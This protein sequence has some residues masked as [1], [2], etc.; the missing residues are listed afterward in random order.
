MSTAIEKAKSALVVI[1]KVAGAIVINSVAMAEKARDLV[2]DLKTLMVD[3]DTM[4]DEPIKLVYD[5]HKELVAE[6]KEL[7]KPIN[8]IKDMLEDKITEWQL[9]Q[10]TGDGDDGA[11]EDDF[12]PSKV[13]AKVKVDGVA[14]VTKTVVT[15]DDRAVLLSAIMDGRVPMDI[16]KFD[17]AKLKKLAS[18]GAPLPGC[19]VLTDKRASVRK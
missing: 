5:E 13:K 2:Y 19:T 18:A 11:D 10:E 8:K 9:S 12:D 7:L 4:Y 15:V 17:M 1:E 14:M 6:K 16:I 3:A